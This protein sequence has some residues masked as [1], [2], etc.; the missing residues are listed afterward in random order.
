MSFPKTKRIEAVGLRI[1]QTKAG[2]L[3]SRPSLRSL[4][5][6]LYSRRIAVAVTRDDFSHL[7]IPI[8]HPAAL[9]GCHTNE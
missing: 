6:G 7:H 9:E 8:C 2:R 3:L 4:A 5:I 1:N